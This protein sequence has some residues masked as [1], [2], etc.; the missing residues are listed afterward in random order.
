MGNKESY[1]QMLEAAK[2]LTQDQIKT[3]SIP[4]GTYIQ[5]AED[6]FV[7]SAK[8]KDQLMNAGI[9]ESVFENLNICASA[10]RHAQSLWN[11]E[12]KSREDAEQQWLDESP[13]AFEF[14]DDLLHAFRYAY[15]NTPALLANV[16]AIAE[17]DDIPDMI[18]DLNDL[19]V[20]GQNNIEPLKK[21]GFAADKLGNAAEL[22]A[23]MADIRALA[24]GDKYES[25]ETL[26]IRNRIYSLLKQN[27]DEINNCGK[28][29]FWKDPNRIK[30]YRSEYMKRKNE[31][32]RNNN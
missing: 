19:A 28:Y 32:Y 20:L 25:S 12:K 5:E 3:P 8:D 7:W 18:Q 9:A 29:L 14:R 4:V 13:K 21:I 30:G 1:D 17:G 10:L 2:S 23:K 22:S 31:S 6:L 16:A 11:E 26:D 27:M 24:N 15:R